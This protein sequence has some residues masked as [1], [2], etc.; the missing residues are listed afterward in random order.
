MT[1][2]QSPTLSPTSTSSA[3]LSPE[4]YD[5]RSE[6]RIDQEFSW[7]DYCVVLS[8]GRIIK[9][10]WD[11]SQENQVIQY[12]RIGKLLQS[13]ECSE[14]QPHGSVREPRTRHPTR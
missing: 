2:V 13:T 6:S 11:F 7:N 12:A 10:K 14:R 9:R 5:D 8:E 3:D 4:D 1:I